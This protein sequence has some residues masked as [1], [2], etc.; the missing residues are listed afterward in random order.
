MR[1]E[2]GRIQEESIIDYVMGEGELKDWV[3]KLEVVDKFNS[4]HHPVVVYK[5]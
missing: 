5:A 3:E 4:D 2:S 1:E